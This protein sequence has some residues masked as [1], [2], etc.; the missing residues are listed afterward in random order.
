M[1][2]TIKQTEKNKQIIRELYLECLNK[3]KWDLLGEIIDENYEGPVPGK[4]P[5]AFEAAVTNILE[6]FPG[7]QFTIQD[8]LAE[9]DKVVVRWQWEAINENPFRGFPASGKKA[10]I[11]GIAIFEFEEDKIIRSWL[12]NEKLEL[13]KQIGAISF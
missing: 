2:T 9:D 4:G 5:M 12:Q 6:A 10:S 1:E 3:R 8:L 7:L 13:M 11:N